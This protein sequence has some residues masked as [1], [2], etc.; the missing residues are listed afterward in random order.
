MSAD[1]SLL[2]LV[3]ER[4]RFPPLFLSHGR[5]EREAMEALLEAYLA[6]A[7]TAA[8]L[9][10]LHLPRNLA[11][12]D[13]FALLQLIWRCRTGWSAPGAV[14]HHTRLW[15]W[16]THLDQLLAYTPK[17]RRE[18]VRALEY[19]V[20]ETGSYLTLWM[21]LEAED[22]DTIKEVK[23]ALGSKLMGFLDVDMTASVV[24]SGEAMPHEP[25]RKAQ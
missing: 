4:I 3:L 16:L 18:V 11:L 19:L 5:P 21:G 23:T 8:E 9:R 12:E 20:E 17:D 25:E 24:E 15:V 2:A 22:A 13:R 1:N 10:K 14:Q 6:D 7:C